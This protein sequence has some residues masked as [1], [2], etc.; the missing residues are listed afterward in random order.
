MQ[1]C[2]DTPPDGLAPHS[3]ATLPKIPATVL[4]VELEL[5]LKYSSILAADPDEAADC[6]AAARDRHVDS[7]DLVEL[8][9]APVQSD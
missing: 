8:S 4:L 9:L 2:F 5:D 3:F 6:A 7:A 1:Y